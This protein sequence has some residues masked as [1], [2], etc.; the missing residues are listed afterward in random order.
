MEMA[1]GRRCIGCPG[2]GVGVEAAGRG[3]DVGDGGAELDTG[4]PR[5]DVGPHES[6]RDY[7]VHLARIACGRGAVRG[8]DDLR[9]VLGVETPHTS[10]DLGEGGGE[11]R[12]ERPRVDFLW[13]LARIAVAV[14]EPASGYVHIHEL[15]M[16]IEGNEGV[17]LPNG[18]M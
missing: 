11:R 9:S 15:A 12:G 18:V 4:R 6:T 17:R 7:A 8:T 10:Y 5:K 16:S 2:D 3:D 13:S 14:S 1:T